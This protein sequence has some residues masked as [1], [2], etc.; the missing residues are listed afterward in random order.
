MEDIRIQKKINIIARLYKETKTVINS[1]GLRF[2]E[3]R[4]ICDEDMNIMQNIII[5]KR[6]ELLEHGYHEND[7]FYQEIGLACAR[8][9]YSCCNIVDKCK[10]YHGLYKIMIL[11]DNMLYFVENPV[12][13]V[14]NRFH[15][16]FAQEL[17]ALIKSKYL[18]DYDTIIE[19]ARGKRYDFDIK[20]VMDNLYT[21][22][23]GYYV[24]DTNSKIYEFADVK[25]FNT[26][27]EE[28]SKGIISGKK[29]SLNN[30]K[31]H[32]SFAS[33]NNF[34]IMIMLNIIINIILL[35]NLD[36]N[37]VKIAI[38]LYNFLISMIYAKVLAD[39]KYADKYHI[40]KKSKLDPLLYIFGKVIEIRL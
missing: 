17:R 3:F 36:Q 19:E 37:G 24:V 23:N 20:Y 22:R 16:L 39:N 34:L 1:V 40:I 32:T 35:T 33:Y 8:Y 29:Y 5:N 2:R 12:N 13:K 27:P 26:C 38:I 25:I 7:V 31:I 4:E 11:Q 14:F 10:I 9:I 18:A 15:M 6:Q 28:L 21:Y 30:A